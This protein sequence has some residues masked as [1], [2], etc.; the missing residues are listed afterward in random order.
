[1]AEIVAEWLDRTI[2][3]IRT[4][5]YKPGA[6]KGLSSRRP[7]VGLALGGGFAR[8]IAHVGVLRV[9]QENQI[10]IDF[11]AGTSVGALI[12]V[13]YAAGAS[14]DEMERQAGST[15]FRDFAE[16]SLSRHGLASDK[17]LEAFVRRL[18]PVRTFGELLIPLAISATDLNSGEAVYF[19]E[20]E[21]GPALCASCAYPGLFRPVENDGRQLVDGFLTAPVPVDGLRRLGAELLIGVHLGSLSPFERPRNIIEVIARSFSIIERYAE[22]TWRYATDIIIQP[23]VRKFRWDDFA[24]TPELIEAGRTA[25]LASLEKIKA[26]LNPAAETPQRPVGERAANEVGRQG[27]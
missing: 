1:V 18:T 6:A 21:L 27:S 16:W 26:A 7:K 24:K 2:R 5:A 17:R 25:A 22:Y 13:G 15:T 9:F 20:G 23:D 14:L 4:F 3:Q 8:G 19:T 10:P 12:G 11:L